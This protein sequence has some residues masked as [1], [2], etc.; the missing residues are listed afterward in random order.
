V[1]KILIGLLIVVVVLVGGAVAAVP[2]IEREAAAQ[3]KADLARDGTQVETVEVGLFD[4]RIAMTNLSGSRTGKITIAHWEASG[5]AWPLR[6]LIQ[7]RTPASGLRLG[8]PLQAKRLQ[9]RDMRMTEHAVNWSVG[10][11]SI[12]DFDLARYDPVIT[13][14]NQFSNLAAR[15]GVALTM[16]RLEQKDTAI[17]DSDGARGSVASLIVHRYD[18]GL[19]GSIAVSSFSISPKASKNPVFTLADFSLTGLDL[20]RTFRSIGAPSWRPGMPIGRVDLAASNI[21]GFGGEAMSLG[22]ITSESRREGDKVMHSSMRIEGFVIAPPPRG[23]ETLQMRIVLQAMGL[24]DL[25]LGFDCK[26]SEDR[27]KAEVTVE[28]CV[29]NGQ[30]LGEIDLSTKLVGADADFWRAVDEGDGMALL[31]TRAGLSGAKLVIADRGLVERSLK[32]VATTSGQPLAAVRAGFAQEI[33]RY[34]PADILITEDMTKLLDTVARFIETGGTLT[35]EAKPDA[36]LGIDKLAYF[37]TPGPDLVR[38]LGLKATL[39]K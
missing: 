4:R 22:R 31:R 32:A 5:I 1:K 33:R 26:G 14:P 18:K 13:G 39:T 8:D 36:P 24:K 6:E 9:V 28:R 2:F 21:S 29:V 12:E 25:R 15:I 20:R 35:I 17:S 23:I 19:V 10:S 27:G 37:S 34:Q 3:I 7:G 38:I 16:G 30:E 11:L